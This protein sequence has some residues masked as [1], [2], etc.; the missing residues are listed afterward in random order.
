[1][2]AKKGSNMSQSRAWMTTRC[3]HAYIA[4]ELRVARALRDECLE[5]AE[6]QCNPTA[7]AYLHMLEVATRYYRCD[8]T[9]AERHFT[10]GLEFFDDQ[11]FRQNPNGGPIAVFGAAAFN[12][13]M[14][15]RPE[16]ARERIAKMTAGVNST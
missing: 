4:G 3:L 9:E 10:R 14:L 7:L 15:G 6:R 12:A 1:M 2:L 13:W 5:P 16:V 8:L 11:R